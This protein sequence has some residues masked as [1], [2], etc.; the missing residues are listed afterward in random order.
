MEEVK[1]HQYQLINKKLKKQ[2]SLINL[3]KITTIQ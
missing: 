1:Y 3:F 2:L